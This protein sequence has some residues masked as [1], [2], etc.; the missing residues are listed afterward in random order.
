MYFSLFDSFKNAT[1]NGKAFVICV[2]TVNGKTVQSSPIPQECL[3]DG[4]DEVAG[5]EGGAA[6]HLW[7]GAGKE[8]TVIPHSQIAAIRVLFQ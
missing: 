7:N 8:L 3:E 1:E 5:A 2:D 4:L 6:I